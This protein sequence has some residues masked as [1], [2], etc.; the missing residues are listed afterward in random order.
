VID[1]EPQTLALVRE[2]LESAGYIAVL[3]QSGREG[4]DLLSRV[5]AGCVVLDLMMP[6][7]DGFEVL[8]AIRASPKIRDLPVIVLTAKD[9][10][11][12]DLERLRSQTTALLTK[13]TD[14]K[15]ELLGCL[16]SIVRQAEEP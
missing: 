14:W 2:I 11:E 1:D 16:R 4:L 13:G 9:L 6:E 10:L 7:M 12:T 3:T 8:A 5:G 15:E